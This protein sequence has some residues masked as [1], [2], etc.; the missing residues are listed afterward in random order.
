MSYQY[1]GKLTDVTNPKCGT[2]AGYMEHISKQTPKCQ[3]CKDAHAAYMRDYKR[4]PTMR[5]TCGT[6]AGYKRHQRADENPC[7]MC[8][9]GYAQ[10]MRDYRDK[11]QAA[12][13][14][15]EPERLPIQERLQKAAELFADG[16][17]Q[18]EVTRTL[19]L[20]RETLRKY[21]PGQGW[22]YRQGGEFRALTRY[23][24]AAA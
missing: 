16:A 13:A 20:S 14:P 15:K 21:F 17:S 12:L 18:R 3:P 4:R 23:E 5:T 22:T 1:R 10:Y 8:L 24:S 19:C 11:K 9:R 6:H 7:G 2:R